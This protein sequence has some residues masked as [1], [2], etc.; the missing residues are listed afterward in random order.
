MTAEIINMF[1]EL[2]P[3][4][5]IA[6]KLLPRHLSYVIKQFR[7]GAAFLD[8][9]I[10]DFPGELAKK[11]EELVELQRRLSL[12]FINEF[13]IRKH[14]DPSPNERKISQNQP[15]KWHFA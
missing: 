14:K 3:L 4:N 15:E 7:K 1:L 10:E 13:D 2:K 6:S 11:V 12:D 8:D 5:E 9:F